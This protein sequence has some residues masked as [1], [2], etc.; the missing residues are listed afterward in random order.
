NWLPVPA[1]YGHAGIA[2]GS[3]LSCHSGTF[4]NIDVKTANHITTTASCDSCHRT[5]AWT[6]RSE[7][8]QVGKAG[9]CATCPNSTQAT[10]KHPSGHV[11]VTAGCDACHTNATSWLPVPATYGHAGIA[12]GS[13]SSCHG[14]TFTNIDVKTANHITTTASC[15]SCHRT[16]AWT[17]AS[18]NHQGV[19]P[20]TFP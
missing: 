12:A 4:T 18:F 20:R 15:D 16:T 14:G 13:C 11:P 19:T 3:C 17:P 8:R 9:S 10:G 5:T 1:T 6:P 7:D 2:A